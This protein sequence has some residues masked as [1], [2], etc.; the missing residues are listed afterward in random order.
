MDEETFTIY[1][2]ANDSAGNINSLHSRTI[3]KDI[4]DPTLNV[5]LPADGT[6]WNARPGVQATAVDT[7]FD[8]VWYVVDGTKIL[9]T[10]GVSELLDQGIW[11]SLS[12]EETF[13]IYF[14]ANDS[15]G[16]VNSLHSRMINKDIS[17][18]ALTVN[19]PTDGTYWN[20][21]PNVQVT[22]TDTNFDSVW[23]VVDGTKI[24]LT[25]GVSELL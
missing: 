14:F 23:Y 7:N 19:L 12:A 20:S 4:T 11:D 2:Y 10:N 17:D 3:H 1:F 8:S 6:Y 13:T 15:A 16:N 25:N 18:P 24:L 9:L 5:D 22:A 21:R